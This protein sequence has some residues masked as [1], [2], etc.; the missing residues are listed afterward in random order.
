M[1]NVGTTIGRPQITM[2][3]NKLEP[4]FYSIGFFMFIQDRGGGIFLYM[5]FH[6]QRPPREFLVRR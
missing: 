6:R 3:I 4:M 1:Y 5:N 2:F